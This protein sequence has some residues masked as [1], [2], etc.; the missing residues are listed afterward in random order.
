MVLSAPATYLAKTLDLLG[1]KD[2]YKQRVKRLVVVDSG[3]RQDAPAMRRILAEW[4]SPIVFCGRQV[5]DSLNFPAASLDTV[6][7]WAPRNPVVDAY[8]A[9]RPMPYDAPLWDM[10]GMLYAVH[11]D[12]NYFQTVNGTLDVDNDG[13]FRFTENAGGAHRALSI[14]PA[15]RDATLQAMIETAGAKPPAPQQRFRQP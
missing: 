7:A 1:T 15:Q 8:R 5:G 6:F 10:A 14:D 11:P 3:E 4:P 12:K 13:A 2:I 9:F